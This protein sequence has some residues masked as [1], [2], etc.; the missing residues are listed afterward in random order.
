[1]IPPTPRGT[2]PATPHTRVVGTVPPGSREPVR[3][4]LHLPYKVIP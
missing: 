1:M 3:T 4:L 2:V